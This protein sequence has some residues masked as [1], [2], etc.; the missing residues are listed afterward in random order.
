MLFLF[1]S[2]SGYTDANYLDLYNSLCINFTPKTSNTDFQLAIDKLMCLRA[3]I[4]LQFVLKVTK[5]RNIT[6]N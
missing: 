2:N 4:L 6:G 3:S 1:D 5:L